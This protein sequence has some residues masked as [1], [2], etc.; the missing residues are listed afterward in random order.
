[1]DE[2]NQNRNCKIE[3]KV[4][5]F[6]QTLFHKVGSRL[7]LFVMATQLE[8]R[9]SLQACLIPGAEILTSEASWVWALTPITIAV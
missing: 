5:L 8:A 3:G 4:T 1:M 6:Q 7:Q 2:K 9:P